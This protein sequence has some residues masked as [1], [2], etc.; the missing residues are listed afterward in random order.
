MN[1]FVKF[2]VNIA[3]VLCRPLFPMKI[4]GNR[5]LEKKKSLIVGNHISGWDPVMLTLWT[6]EPIPFVYKATFQNSPF[7]TWIFNGMECV[8]IRRGEVDINAS[9]RVLRLLKDNK[10]VCL[11]PEGTRNAYV[12]CLQDFRPGTALFALKTHAPIRP[13]YI[14]DRP[15]FLRK[16]YII[17]GEEFTLGEFYGKPINHNTLEEATAIIKSKVEQLR[18]QLNEILLSQGIKRRP[19]T[20][21]ELKKI[22]AYEEKQRLLQ[23]E[24]VGES[25]QDVERHSRDSEVNA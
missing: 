15:S 23:G 5:K 14:W 7:L 6:K 21:K 20:K 10:P 13:F 2:L 25:V 17:F 19:R 3:K 24:N 12:D 9:K 8:P 11:F 18:L 1:R 22:A 16:N 4:Y